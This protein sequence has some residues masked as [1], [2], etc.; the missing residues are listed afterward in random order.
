MAIDKARCSCCNNWFR[1]GIE[2]VRNNRANHGWGPEE[3]PHKKAGKKKAFKRVDHKHI[4]VT[5]GWQKSFNWNGSYYW[6]RQYECLE[7]GKRGKVHYAYNY[8]NQ[9]IDKPTW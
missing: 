6:R 9:N 3:L 2:K 5:D 4:Y 7:C 8:Y 1:D